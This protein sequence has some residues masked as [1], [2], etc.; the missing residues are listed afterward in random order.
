MSWDEDFVS[1]K[2]FKGRKY[3]ELSEEEMERFD[4]KLSQN[5]RGFKHG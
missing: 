5:F 1:R 3:D 2:Y 4:K